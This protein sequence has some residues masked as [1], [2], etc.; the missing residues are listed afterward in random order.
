MIAA[1][2]LYSCAA[3][4]EE[5]AFAHEETITPE[6]VLNASPLYLNAQPGDVAPV[7]LLTLSDEMTIFLDE[8]VD[9]NGNQSQILAQ[10]IY[11]L[12]R[13]DQFL[14]AY[15]DSTRTAESTFRER[16]GNCISFTNMFVA[17]ARDLGLDANYQEVTIPPDWS[18]SGQTI[19]L[20]QHVSV[21]VN[22][23]SA[24]S[25]VVDFN[26]YST[27]LPLDSRVIADERARAHYFNNI[28]VEHMLADETPK[29]FANFRESLKNDRT[30]SPSWANLGSLYRR[31]GFPRYAEAA[32]LAALEQNKSNL[33]AM[34]NLANLYEEEG[35]T[36][37]AQKYLG[38]VQSHRTRNPYYRFQLA[39][40]AFI[41]GDYKTAIQH[42]KY[43]IRKR[44]EEDRFYFLLSLSYLMSGEKE[45]AKVWM[46]KAKELARLSASKKKY[47]HKL[48]LLKSRDNG[49]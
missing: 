45:A 4:N 48:D 17:M 35:N 24:L 15:D 3:I 21:L 31:E 39:N 42:L 5:Y 6:M 41:D 12:I 46:E 1:G 36:K 29:A 43:A 49:F 30:F 28:G 47:Q 20:S 32:Y 44:E 22:L 7:D 40:S 33:T 27:T 23:K 34:S 18:M 13:E 19:L 25:R 8:H 10:L 11:A 16:R 9:R 37:A 26:T 14:L 38:R 2:T